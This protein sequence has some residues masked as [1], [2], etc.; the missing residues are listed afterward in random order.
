MPARLPS[1]FPETTRVPPVLPEW[2]PAARRN[3]HRGHRG[4]VSMQRRE[5]GEWER[6][7]GGGGH[8]AVEGNHAMCERQRCPDQ[9]GG[10]DGGQKGA[11]RAGGQQRLF[12]RCLRPTD[13]DGRAAV[14]QIGSL[15]RTSYFVARCSVRPSLRPPARPSA[16]S[17][18]V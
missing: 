7:G 13:A 4:W 2:P 15:L 5:E 9:P 10:Q 11:G 18:A 8:G 17:A 14:C 16:R 12:V 1:P 6:E 3:Y